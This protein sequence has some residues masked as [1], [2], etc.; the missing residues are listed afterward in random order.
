MRISL[1]FLICFVVLLFGTINAQKS[2]NTG[3]IESKSAVTE[4]DFCSYHRCQ[5]CKTDADC[6]ADMVCQY[7]SGAGTCHRRPLFPGYNWND[8]AGTILNFFGAMLAAGGGLG[9]GGLFVPIFILCVGLLP[10]EAIPLSQAMIFGG[11][12]ANMIMNSQNSHPLFPKRP[13]VDYSALLVLQ[14]PM[15][16]GTMF[17]VLLQVMS[18]HWFVL[19][20]LAVTLCYT[21]FKTYNKAVTLW[22]DESGQAEHH[23]SPA[24]TSENVHLIPAPAVDSDPRLREIETREATWKTSIVWIVLLWTVVAIFTLLRGGR[25][26]ATSV[27]GV[28]T[29]SATYW[30]LTALQVPLLLSITWFVGR[31]LST[32][33]AYKERVRPIVKGDIAWTPQ[34]IILY[35]FWSLF[36][37]TLGGMLGIGGGMIMGPLLLQL[38]MIPEVAA[39]TS[40]TTVFISSSAAALNFYTMGL[41]ME[42]YALWYMSIGFIATFL[43]QT[44]VSFLIKKYKRSSIIVIV[45]TILIAIATL[46]L[47]ISGSIQVAHDIDHGE[48]LGF[49][50][51]C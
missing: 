18:P 23:Y 38:G 4:V 10:E 41:L 31:Q 27:A 12:I 24:P 32:D 46:M 6:A 45:V 2:A 28:Y 17:G 39:A 36:A 42:D 5:S 30:V 29:C 8:F 48:H 1:A 40:A 26:H 34:N 25:P 20:L 13:L 43:G 49:Q 50:S 47:F 21:V 33:Y 19:G 44:V 16:I 15:L 35:P 51:F 9:G 14:P 3:F 11:A 22:K 37:G 7:K